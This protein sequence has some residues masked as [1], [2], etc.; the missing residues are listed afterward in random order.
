MV[1]TILPCRAQV[2]IQAGEEITTRYVSSTLGNCRRRRDLSRYWY[3]DCRCVRCRDSTE[4]GTHMSSVRCSCGEGL[5][6]KREALDWDSDWVCQV[7]QRS[8]PGEDIVRKV[9][10]I[11]EEIAEV[12]K[13][14]TEKLVGKAMNLLTID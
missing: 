4:L 3:F 6:V 12:D 9:D 8:V 2:A 5:C 13:T 11:E 7:C 1:V 10:Q 14:D